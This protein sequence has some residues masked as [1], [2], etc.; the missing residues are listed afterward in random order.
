MAYL[1]FLQRVV[2][3]A[4]EI[5]AALNARVVTSEHI[6]Q[7]ADAVLLDIKLF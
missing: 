2:K 3:E 4:H 7:A 5:A 1:L 6:R